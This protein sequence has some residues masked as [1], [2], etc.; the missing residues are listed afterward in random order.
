MEEN[1]LKIFLISGSPKDADKIYTALE[2]RWL[3]LKIKKS[4]IL[5]FFDLELI[6]WT[7]RRKKIQK[8]KMDS[9]QRRSWQRPQC[10]RKMLK[11]VIKQKVTKTIYNLVN[12]HWYFY[13]LPSKLQISKTFYASIKV[14]KNKL[15]YFSKNIFILLQTPLNIFCNILKTKVMIILCN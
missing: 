7:M 8:M 2:Y 13:E 15:F 12:S 6:N 9:H 3:K 14:F 5:G 1:D 10:P 11:K 4:N